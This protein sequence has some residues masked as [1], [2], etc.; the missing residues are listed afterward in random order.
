MRSFPGCWVMPG[1]SLDPGETLEEAGARELRE[2]CGVDVAPADLTPLAMWE[3]TFPTRYLPPRPSLPPPPLDVSG[4]EAEAKTETG[5]GRREAPAATA[6]AAGPIPASPASPSD[7]APAPSGPTVQRHHLIVF[8][9]A[10]F[11]TAPAILRFSSDEVSRACFL[12][13]ARIAEVMRDPDNDHTYVAGGLDPLSLEVLPERRGIAAQPDSLSSVSPAPLA[14]ALGAAS[15][16]GGVRGRGEGDAVGTHDE[17]T[18]NAR[19]AIEDVRGGYPNSRSRGLGEGHLFALRQ[20]LALAA[21]STA[22]SP[23]GE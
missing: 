19:I 11:P 20:L 7:S 15:E 18:R 23:A 6:A 21:T 3:S 5:G 17:G 1:G 12:P 9:R 13:H 10:R 4:A 16:A 2:E 14:P 8:F 22:T